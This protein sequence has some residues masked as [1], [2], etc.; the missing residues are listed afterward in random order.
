MLLKLLTC[1][2]R[3]LSEALTAHRKLAPTGA[4]GP[5]LLMAARTSDPSVASP[6]VLVT[7]MAPSAML[8]Q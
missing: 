6:S 5:Y 3:K 2:C 8:Q 7:L 1:S 4:D